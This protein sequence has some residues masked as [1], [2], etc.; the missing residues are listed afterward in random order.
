MAQKLK[1][2]KPIPNREFTRLA[3]RVIRKNKELLQMLAN[4]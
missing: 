4:V 1:T 2:A 3:E